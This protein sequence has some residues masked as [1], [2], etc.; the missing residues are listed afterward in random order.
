M[1]NSSHVNRRRR[2]CSSRQSTVNLSKSVPSS[3]PLEYIN[4]L[5]GK[6]FDTR[7]GSYSVEWHI[8]STIYSTVHDEEK[9]CQIDKLLQMLWADRSTNGSMRLYVLRHFKPTANI[10]I[11]TCSERQCWC[12]TGTM[13]TTITLSA[14][15]VNLSV[16]ISTK[17]ALSPSSFKNYW[18]TVKRYIIQLHFVKIWLCDGWTDGKRTDCDKQKSTYVLLWNPPILYICYWLKFKLLKYLL[19]STGPILDKLCL[20]A[21]LCYQAWNIFYIKK[22][23]PVKKSPVKTANNTPMTSF[24][25]WVSVRSFFHIVPM[26]IQLNQ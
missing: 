18:H 9:C 3:S 19:Q 2:S 12:L 15:H 25:L 16:L 7:S 1:Q 26:R 11:L 23:S 17:L 24:A 4:F 21:K 8:N 13:N 22:K 10:S 6:S 14:Q 20:A 5:I